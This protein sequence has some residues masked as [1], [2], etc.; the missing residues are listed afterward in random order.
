MFNEELSQPLW[1]CYTLLQLSQEVT[2]GRKH[3]HTQSFILI[4]LKK[5]IK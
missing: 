1:L 5:S 4:F 3:K 2:T